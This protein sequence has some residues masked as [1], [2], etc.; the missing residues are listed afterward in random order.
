MLFVVF[1]AAL[2]AL[3]S[4]RKLPEISRFFGI[5]IRMFVEPAVRHH[6]PH[7]HAYYQND[8]V[9]IAIDAISVIAGGLPRRQQRM[10][11]AW[12]EIHQDE[13]LEDWA[14]LQAGKQP[15]AIE[16]LR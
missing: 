1:A 2:A 11:E 14:R 7:F 8:V 9:I 3:G 10:V 16:Q 13:L 12:A 4:M 15:F 5:I 6:R